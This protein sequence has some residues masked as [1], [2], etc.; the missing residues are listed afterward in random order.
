MSLGVAKPKQLKDFKPVHSEW[1]GLCFGKIGSGQFF[2][3]VWS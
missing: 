3:L 1:R 2:L